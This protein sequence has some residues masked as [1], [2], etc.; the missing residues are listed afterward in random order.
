MPVTPS[1]RLD[2]ANGRASSATRR[3]GL[4][5]ASILA[6]MVIAACG[7]SASKPAYCSARTNLENSVKGLKSL[8]LSSGVS[9]LEAQLTKIK[10]DAASVVSSAKADFPSQT[11]AIKTSVDSLSSAVKSVSST[12]S[13]AQIASIT[14]DAASVM[15]SVKSFVDATSSK[16]S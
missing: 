3:A 15:S 13:A 4:M 2:Q 1:T 5:A 14:A 6:L 9:G 12:P 8:S 10:S 7:S 11:S 16:C